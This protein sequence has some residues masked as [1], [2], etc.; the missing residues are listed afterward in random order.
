MVTGS[1][2]TPLCAIYIDFDF[3]LKKMKPDQNKNNRKLKPNW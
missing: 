1:D 3:L 2:F